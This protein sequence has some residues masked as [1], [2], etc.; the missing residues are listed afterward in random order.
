[1]RILRALFA[2]IVLAVPLAVLTGVGPAGACSCAVGSDQQMF[3]SSDAVFTA[4]LTRVE[5]PD[6]GSST[7]PRVY[8]FEVDDVLKGDV[9]PQQVV[10]SEQSGASCGLEIAGA[11]PFI[12]FAVAAVHESSDIELGTGELCAGLCGGTRAISA[13][14]PLD[15]AVAA[16]PRAPDAGLV[17]EPPGDDSPASDVV[18][19]VVLYAVFVVAAIIGVRSVFFDRAPDIPVPGSLPPASDEGER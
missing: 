7:A 10:R 4:T 1:V 5:D 12:V 9:A 16:S 13:G 2:T 15:A 17:V 18:L 19:R 8:T 3:D 11:G 14:G 6:S